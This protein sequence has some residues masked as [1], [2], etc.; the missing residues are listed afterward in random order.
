MLQFISENK[1]VYSILIIGLIL[2]LLFFGGTLIQSVFEVGRQVGKSLAQWL[3]IGAYAMNGIKSYKALSELELR[4]TI[5]GVTIPSWD[6]ITPI[7]NAGKEVGR[8]IA[9]WI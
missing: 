7:F 1:L 9:K 4:Y 6:F 5:G 8:A 3:Q 2:Y